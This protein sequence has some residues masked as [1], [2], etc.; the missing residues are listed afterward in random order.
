MKNPYQAN[1]PMVSDFR[2]YTCETCGRN[3]CIPEIGHWAYKRKS[4]ANGVKGT[5]VFC[6][7]SCMRSFDN[8]MVNR[9]RVVTEKRVQALTEK[10]EERRKKA[11]AAKQAEAAEKAEE[12]TAAEAVPVVEV[13]EEKPAAEEPIVTEEPV[14]EEPKPRWRESNKPK[15]VMT[16]DG[17]IFGSMKQAGRWLFANANPNCR[18]AKALI[19]RVEDGVKTGEEFEVNGVKM[20]LATEED[21]W[22]GGQI[23][24]ERK[25]LGR[26]HL[27]RLQE[28][29]GRLP[30]EPEAE[31][32]AGMDGEAGSAAGVRDVSCDGVS[33][34][35]SG[36]G[37]SAREPEREVDGRT[38]IPHEPTYPRHYGNRGA[39]VLSECRGCFPLDRGERVLENEEP[40][41]G[42]GT[43]FE[44]EPGNGMDGEAV[45]GVWTGAMLCKEL[46]DMEKPDP[47]VIGMNLVRLRTR[48][49]LSLEQVSALTGLSRWSVGHWENGKAVPDVKSAFKIA[50]LYRTTLD[51]VL[52][53]IPNESVWIPVSEE[54]SVF[55]CGNCGH[56]GVADKAYY[57]PHC[58]KR[59]RR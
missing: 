53:G 48:A 58:G 30:M 9:K 49:R 27:H 19:K 28:G 52:T 31:A 56:L 10:A 1:D 50:K 38:D 37:I 41:D 34:V 36:R 55:M 51:C 42:D 13:V 2:E 57:C 21:I 29:D 18:T 5:K 12:T 33:G 22:N 23:Y 35:R 45:Q 11:E 43:Y 24:K 15:M 8:D 25:L 54:N 20:R 6:S 59:M 40:H 46:M 32:G 3:L 44:S 14:K 39:A 26:K 4:Q 7:Y 16:A 47:E 17:I